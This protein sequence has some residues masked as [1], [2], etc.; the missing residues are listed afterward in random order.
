MTQR[1]FNV[2]TAVSCSTEPD[3]EHELAKLPELQQA[4]PA[5]AT[6]KAKSPRNFDSGSTQ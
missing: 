3:Q 5:L 2:S 4:R 1:G 6:A